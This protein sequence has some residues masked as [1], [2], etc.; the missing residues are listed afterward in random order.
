MIILGHGDRDLKK[1]DTGSLISSRSSVVH[2]QR[3]EEDVGEIESRPAGSNIFKRG[4][5]PTW[6]RAGKP[7]TVGLPY[8]IRSAKILSIPIAPPLAAPL[9]HHCPTF[10]VIC[11]LDFFHLQIVIIIVCI[12]K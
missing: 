5:R 4:Y 11:F 7:R 9:S 2:M 8:R 10:P 12:Y 6:E 1:N 3:T